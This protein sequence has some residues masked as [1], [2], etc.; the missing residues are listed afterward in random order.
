MLRTGRCLCV[1]QPGGRES[2]KDRPSETKKKKKNP[3]GLLDGDR[4]R[5][6]R[7]VRDSSG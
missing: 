2:L 4:I 3:E 6:A 5:I 7:I 1:R